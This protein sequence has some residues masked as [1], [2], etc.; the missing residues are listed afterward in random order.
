VTVS[1]SRIARAIALGALFVAAPAF[2][3]TLRDLPKPSREIED[4]FSL[5]AAA[6][7]LRPGVV[8]AV[9]GTELELM[10]V[11]FAK[12]SKTA[13]GRQGSGPGEYRA[14]AGLFRLHGDTIWVLDAT[15]QRLVAFNPDLTAGTTIPLLTFD[16]STMTA[17]TAPFLGDRKGQLYASAMTIQA[18]RSG[19]NMQMSI[20]DSVG[21]VR[22]DPRNKSVRTELA[23]VRFPTSGKPEMKQNGT[24]IK[25]S[26]AYPGL[27]ASDPWTV[28]PDGRIAIVRGANYTVEFIGADGKKSAPTRIA[29]EPIKVTEADQKAEMDEARKQM[30]D[31]AKTVQKM[32]PAGISMEFELLAPADWPANYPAVSPLGALAAPDGRLWVRRSIPFRSGHEEWDVIDQAGKLV[33]RWKLPAKTTIVAIGQGVVYTVRTDEDDLRYLQRVEIGR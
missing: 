8:L 28:F 33:A 11:D 5:V 7:E 23:R 14:P 16:Q 3:Q 22:V 20:P 32:M 19:G 27:V 30:K 12:G 9:D 26:M 17:L 29:Y 4:P 21:V 15:Q 1:I 31:Q 10:L 13:V 6:I 2:A 25:M 18:G 24:S